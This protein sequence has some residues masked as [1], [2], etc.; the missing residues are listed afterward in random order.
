MKSSNVVLQALGIACPEI[1]KR[2]HQCHLNLGLWWHSVENVS[3]LKVIQ[4]I[5]PFHLL[6]EAF[7]YI[8]LDFPSAYILLRTLSLHLYLDK[9]DDIYRPPYAL[10]TT[11]DNR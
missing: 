5:L 9:A 3:N 11:T 2:S 7:V 4:P 8:H 10:N 1:L 6:R